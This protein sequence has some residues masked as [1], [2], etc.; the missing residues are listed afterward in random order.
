[1]IQ[2]E[3]EAR[4]PDVIDSYLS[5]YDHPHDLSDGRPCDA[6]AIRPEL[7]RQE[8]LATHNVPGSSTFEK[9]AGETE[10]PSIPAWPLPKPSP[11]LPEKEKQQPE[12][13]P[14]EIE[15]RESKRWPKVP[16]GTSR[17]KGMVLSG[18]KSIFT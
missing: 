1:M 6:G 17:R 14:R 7:R 9:G 11:E 2:D 16:K 8:L 10:D 18:I 13:Q 3:N 15:K 4:T 12:K 5:P